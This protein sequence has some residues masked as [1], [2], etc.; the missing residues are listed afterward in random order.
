MFVIS[1]AG[2]DLH[3]NLTGSDKTRRDHSLP[4]RLPDSDV[5]AND[6]RTVTL[7]NKLP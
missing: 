3:L 4:V 6:S 1:A 7:S 5:S 2:S